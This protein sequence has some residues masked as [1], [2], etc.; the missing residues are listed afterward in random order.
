MQNPKKKN[1]T[2]FG[3]ISPDKAPVMCFCMN[4]FSLFLSIEFGELECC[5]ERAASEK[6]DSER[7]TVHSENKIEIR[8]LNS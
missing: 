3:I 6:R 5:C 7:K 8:K 1:E 2:L 4:H